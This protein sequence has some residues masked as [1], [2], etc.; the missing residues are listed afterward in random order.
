MS[1]FNIF[2]DDHDWKAS[3]RLVENAEA[4]LVLL[5]HMIA[6]TYEQDGQYWP[7]DDFDHMIDRAKAITQ[8]IE[9]GE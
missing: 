3:D 6:A 7:T 9:I 1:K 8:H 4:M 5:K 2:H